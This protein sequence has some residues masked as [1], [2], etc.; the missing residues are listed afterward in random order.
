MRRA[1]K[2]ETGHVLSLEEGAPSSNSESRLFGFLLSG[3]NSAYRAEFG[4]RECRNIM[5][6]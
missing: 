1:K 5:R 6:P 3:E 4:D 2:R